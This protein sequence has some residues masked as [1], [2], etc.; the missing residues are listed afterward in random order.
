MRKSAFLLIPF[1]AGLSFGADH[2]VATWGTSPAPQLADAARRQ[3]AK[4]VFE[5]QT[6]RNI[7]HVSIGGDSLR[8]RF[9]NAYGTE[10]LVIGT[11]HIALRE[12]DSSTVTGTDRPLTFGGNPSITIPA[13]ALAV[14]DP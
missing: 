1:L 4:L 14:S 11:A 9:S 2:W 3:Q 13:N 7:V 10:P 8:V 12:A 5:D 6:V